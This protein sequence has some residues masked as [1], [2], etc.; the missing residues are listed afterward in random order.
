MLASSPFGRRDGYLR[1]R[2]RPEY[3]EA[4]GECGGRGGAAFCVVMVNYGCKMD[5]GVFLRENEN[6][7]VLL[8]AHL[9]SGSSHSRAPINN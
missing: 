8:F 1:Q 3:L 9:C 2:R 7:F 6:L 5:L 4:G